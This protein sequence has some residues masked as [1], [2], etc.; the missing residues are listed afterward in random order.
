MKKCP[1]CR[2]SGKEI[3]E[4][5]KDQSK[6][7]KTCKG[8]GTISTGNNLG[9]KLAITVIVMVVIFGLG[10]TVFSPSS[11]YLFGEGPESL[12]PDPYLLHLD[13]AKRAETC[14]NVSCESDAL[15]HYK[16]ALEINPE[17]RGAL[18]GILG[19]LISLNKFEEA[20]KYY[21]TITKLYPEKNFVETI[22]AVPMF[23]GLKQYDDALSSSE[24]YLKRI[25]GKKL[26]FAFEYSLALRDKARALIGLERFEEAVLIIDESFE[27]R[28][29][30]DTLLYK[31][32]ALSKQGKYNE[33]LEVFDKISKEGTEGIL[34]DL[35]RGIVLWN[36]GK[37]DEAKEILLNLEENKLESSR[38]LD[39]EIIDARE[40]LQNL[41]GSSK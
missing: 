6:K 10:A 13:K 35:E 15:N 32:M 20:Y 12:K 16:M 14:N 37:F 8:K 5:Q 21:Q 11:E 40:H 4:L 39:S 38:F 25:E 17:G 7:C 36:V 33:A 26:E 22:H 28:P 27:L 34:L 19:E 23:L 3:K 29:S 1:N 24:D 2:G 18:D 30:G 41:V 9:I 31:G